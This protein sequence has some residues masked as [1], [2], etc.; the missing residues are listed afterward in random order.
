MTF[1]G[2]LLAF[3]IVCI[4]VMIL[5]FRAPEMEC[6]FTVPGGALFI[7]LAGALS[8]GA[9]MMSMDGITWAR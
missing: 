9:V 2:T 5:R 8:C 7:P 6:C 4:A 3:V 1:I